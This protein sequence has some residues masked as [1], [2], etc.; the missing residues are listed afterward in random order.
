[1]DFEKREGPRS[2]NIAAKGVRPAG[3]HDRSG[4]A[5]TV[6]GH[7]RRPPGANSCVLFPMRVRK[8]RSIASLLRLCDLDGGRRDC[9]DQSHKLLGDGQRPQSFDASVGAPDRPADEYFDNA[10]FSPATRRRA[11]TI[12][13]RSPNPGLSPVAEG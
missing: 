10:S 3:L 13:S 9:R 6:A 1:M 7:F 2:K 11:S 5:A 12:G 4:T 8:L